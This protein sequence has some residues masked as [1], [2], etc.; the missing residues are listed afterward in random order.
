[1]PKFAYFFGG[2]VELS[3][4]SCLLTV[5]DFGHPSIS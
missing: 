4:E 1:M 2:R 3:R 5:G